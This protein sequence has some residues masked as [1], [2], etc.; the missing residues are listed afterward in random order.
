MRVIRPARSPT[1]PHYS[2]ILRP[3]SSS[4]RERPHQL[5]HPGMRPAVESPVA[6]AD[7][8]G[9][10]VGHDERCIL[11]VTGN[12]I[13]NSPAIKLVDRTNEE[14]RRGRGRKRG[15]DRQAVVVGGYRRRNQARPP[16]G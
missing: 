1:P 5:N 7:R 12:L 6:A 8:S 10:M 9:V 3:S 4:R 15:G 16:P 11:N 2:S 13:H 14:E